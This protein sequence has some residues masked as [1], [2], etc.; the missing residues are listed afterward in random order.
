VAVAPHRREARRIQASQGWRALDL[1][2]L[3]AYRELIYFL[4]WRDVKV[5]YR[6]TA[7]GVIWAILQ[8]VA[9]MAIF[10]VFLGNIIGSPSGE[11]PYA[12]FALSGLVPWTYFANAAT[13]SSSS[14]VANTNLVSKVY[15]PRLAIPLSAVLSGLV[16]FGVGFVLVLS[17]VVVYRVP[18]GASL[19]LMPVVV[20]LAILT[21]TSVGIWLSAL[22][23]QYRDVRYAFPFFIQVWMFATP[24][25]YPA[26]VLREDARA[27]LG[28]NPMV[29]VV[30]GFRWALLGESHVSAAL[31]VGSMLTM[32]L[33]LTTG[34]LYFRRMER[35]FAD[36]I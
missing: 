18:I 23:V 6:Q 5:R 33:I 24:V 25:I 10:T 21:A 16:D 13:N 8:P 17:L 12:V 20:I 2:E 15:F 22:D 19:L 9:A 4:A 3:W 11:V 27:L 1:A 36:V 34:L 30:E 35:R 26:S 14:L 28:L 32:L 7:L 29:A 31:I